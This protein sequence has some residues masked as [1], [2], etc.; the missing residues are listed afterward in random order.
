MNIPNMNYYE[1]LGISVDT[2]DKEIREA[3]LNLVKQ[4]HPDV[5]K[6]EDAEE[7]IKAI[8]IAYDTLIDDKKRKKYNQ[9]IYTNQTNY[10]TTNNS[11]N[12]DKIIAE[13]KNNI[14]NLNYELDCISLKLNNGDVKSLKNLDMWLKKASPL[15][16]QILNLKK[17]SP[18]YNNTIKSLAKALYNM[19]KI[20]LHYQKNKSQIY[21]KAVSNIKEK[22]FNLDYELECFCKKAN[23]GD[24]SAIE[25]LDIISN[26]IINLYDELESLEILLLESLEK[27]YNTI[28]IQ[29]NNFE[30]QKER[31]I[32]Q[33]F[34]KVEAS[35]RRCMCY[36]NL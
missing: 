32:E 27:D 13:L 16:N 8:N 7:K 28:T 14:F 1:I 29:L 2:T 23:N 26:K 18:K 21:Q 34:Q 17:Q 11:E 30:K 35:K 25:N 22:I 15:Y 31:K 5:Y 24:L 33:M 4:Y 36:G 9:T 12:L 19:L 6:G 20:A 3:Y 10:T